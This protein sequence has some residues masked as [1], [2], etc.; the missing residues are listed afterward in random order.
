MGEHWYTQE[1]K[2]RHWQE[3]GKSTTLRHARVQD[4]VPS[5][6][7]ILNELNKPQLNDWKTKEA[8]KMAMETARGDVEPLDHYIRRVLGLTGQKTGQAAEFGTRFHAEAEK[9]NLYLMR[10]GDHR[11]WTKGTN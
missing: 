1:G 4:L 6:T 10:E 5:V 2:P 7:S 9:V 11:D 8:L 3:D